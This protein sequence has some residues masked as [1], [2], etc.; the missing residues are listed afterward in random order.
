MLGTN[1]LEYNKKDVKCS[2]NYPL[3]KTLIC[4]SMIFFALNFL[5][6]ISEVTKN[7]YI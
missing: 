7:Q 2:A 1:C 6:R 3:S 4:Y 5:I